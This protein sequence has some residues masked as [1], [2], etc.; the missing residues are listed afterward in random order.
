MMTEVQ[1]RALK[2]GDKVWMVRFKWRKPQVVEL[3]VWGDPD[4]QGRVRW[5]QN[6]AMYRPRDEKQY[7]ANGHYFFAT[8]EEAA[9]T[10]KHDRIFSKQK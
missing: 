7:K 5:T 1:M 4:E 2:S 3:T 8:R 9:N 6:F 10:I